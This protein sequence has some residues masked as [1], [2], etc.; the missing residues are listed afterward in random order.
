MSQEP[1]RTEADAS[2]DEQWVPVRTE[3]PPLSAVQD[4][5]RQ[6]TQLALAVAAI[7]ERLERL[8][9]GGSGETSTELTERRAAI[10]A[11]APYRISPYD[12]DTIITASGRRIAA[13]Y[14]LEDRPLIVQALNDA[15]DATRRRQ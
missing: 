12:R 15:A 4:L 10:L 5:Q 7:T 2:R 8:E 3:D 13:V 6:C 9:G 14:T 1:E 11:D